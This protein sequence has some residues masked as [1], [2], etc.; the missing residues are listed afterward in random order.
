M[1]EWHFLPL[2]ST[3]SLSLS[4]SSRVASVT[5]IQWSKVW[6]HIITHTQTHTRKVSSS[7]RHRLT[8]KMFYKFSAIFTLHHVNSFSCINMNNSLFTHSPCTIHFLV[9]SLHV[10]NA[11]EIFFPLKRSPEQL[12][13]LVLAFAWCNNHFVTNHR[14]I[15]LCPFFFFLFL[16]YCSQW[17]K[18]ASAQ[19]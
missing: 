6:T 18:E 9:C 15:F 4:P 11:N 10:E 5:V 2:A 7:T 14:V 16:L 19:S 3:S 1:I 13:V 17:F 12:L 8:Q